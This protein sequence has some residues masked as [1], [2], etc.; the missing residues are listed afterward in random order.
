MGGSLSKVSRTLVFG[1]GEQVIVGVGDREFGGAVKGL[2]QAMDDV[3]LV[4]DALEEGADL[5]NFDV[6]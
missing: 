1:K 6:E 2:L 5:L 4:F 3:N